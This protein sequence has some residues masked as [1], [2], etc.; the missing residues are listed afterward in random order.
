ME[1]AAGKK[2]LA[3][4][5]DKEGIPLC[6]KWTAEQVEEFITWLGF[7]QYVRCFRDNYID[8]NR[9]INI[10]TS[11]LPKIGI[12]DFEHIKTI[13]TA[14]STFLGIESEQWDRSITLCDREPL[15]HYLKRKAF[16]GPKSNDLTFK[17]HLR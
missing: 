17:D 8:G 2:E 9:L 12:T 4:M 13:S 16:T 7:P 11:T 5:F 6:Q 14:I 10:D 3:P 1:D 15:S